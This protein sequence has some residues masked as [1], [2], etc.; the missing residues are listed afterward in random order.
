[1]LDKKNLFICDY[2]GSQIRIHQLQEME[3][4]DVADRHLSAAAA[5]HCKDH[6]VF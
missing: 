1:L 2:T 3:R 6:Y 4:N 5:V